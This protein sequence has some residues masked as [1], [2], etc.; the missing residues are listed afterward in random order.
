MIGHIDINVMPI[1]DGTIADFG[2]MANIEGKFT[3]IWQWTQDDNW[4]ICY[5]P[6]LNYMTPGQG[7]WIWMAEDSP[8]SGT[9]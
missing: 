3:Q 4:D 2:S 7:Y 8:M 6:G 5:P 9:P 1:D